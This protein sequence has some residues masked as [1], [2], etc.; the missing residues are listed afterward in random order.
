MLFGSHNQE[1]P[2]LARE[3]EREREVRKAKF[4]VAGYTVYDK[5][6]AKGIRP[7]GPTSILGQSQCGNVTFCM[8]DFWIYLS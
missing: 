2:G 8:H 4:V 5:L 6:E 7:I 3:G 1:S